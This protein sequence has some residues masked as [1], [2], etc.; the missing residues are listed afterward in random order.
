VPFQPLDKWGTFLRVPAATKRLVPELALAASAM[1]VFDTWIDNGDRINDGNLLVGEDP[2][3]K[4]VRYAYIDHANSL[5]Q[6]WRD[7]PPAT[8]QRAIGPYPVEVRLDGRTIGETIVAIE[9]LSDGHIQE[10]VDRIPETF[11]SLQRKACIRDGLC[12]RR[13]DLRGALVGL[14]G[15]AL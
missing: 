7:G 3:R 8:I 5:T 11:I 12:R 2:D 13:H 9:A 10:A 15:V 14:I 6:G 1:L 4:T